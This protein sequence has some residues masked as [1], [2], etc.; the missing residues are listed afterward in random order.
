MARF[1]DWVDSRVE[2]LSSEISMSD[3]LYL[4]DSTD[5][6]V[7]KSTN[8]GNILAGVGLEDGNGK[9]LEEKLPYN[10]TVSSIQ[11][12][13]TSTL[14]LSN[15]SLGLN[16]DNLTLHDGS[17]TGG[18]VI[19]SGTSI[20]YTGRI[21]V[22]GGTV[23]QNVNY[24]GNP[25][26]TVELEKYAGSVIKLDSAPLAFY[27]GL[28]LK[29]KFDCSWRYHITTYNGNILLDRPFVIGVVP[30]NM[31]PEVSGTYTRLEEEFGYVQNL[32]NGCRVGYGHIGETKLQNQV[33][34]TISGD[35]QLFNN[36]IETDN[37][38]GNTWTN[39]TPLEFTTLMNYAPTLS[40]I[41]PTTFSTGNQSIY[42]NDL[43]INNEPEFGTSLDLYLLS[44]LQYA[45][46]G[47]FFLYYDVTVDII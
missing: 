42:A 20:R 45:M 6:T 3:K 5:S 18:N 31:S 8:I 16:G 36:D 29:L 17:T 19:R 27:D 15:G 44:T 37:P 46:T 4:I 30:N 35:Y 41:N 47:I 38:P 9:I 40:L 1:I 43:I 11:L 12:T 34:Y 24:A 25:A 22:S 32:I 28:K 7:S 21:W 13:D 10:I 33:I 2:L 14:I 23:Y 39:G 26:A